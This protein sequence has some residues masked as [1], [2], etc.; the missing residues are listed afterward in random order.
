M[1]LLQSRTLR[2]LAAFIAAALLT[3]S[4]GVAGATQLMGFSSA[5]FDIKD[6]SGARVI[7]HARYEVI[8]KGDVITLHGDSRYTS[9]EYD[10]EDDSFQTDSGGNPVLTTAKH[11]FYRSGGTPMFEDDV[12]FKNGRAICRDYLGSTPNIQDVQMSFPPDTWIGATVMLPIRQYFRSG[13]T[14]MSFHAFFCAPGPKIFNVAVIKP[15]SPTKAPSGDT[16]AV[17][18]NMRPTFGWLDVFTRPFVP[19][20]HVW[21]DPSHDWEVVGAEL[22]RYYKGPDVLLARTGGSALTASGGAAT[23]PSPA[24]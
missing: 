12:D 19:T 20:M 2:Y 22:L 24:H 7:G 5:E 16:Q 15:S 3:I 8:Q 21:F 4:A 23:A 13:G 17:E 11:D 18:V 14:Q 10:I 9:G 6:P 1:R